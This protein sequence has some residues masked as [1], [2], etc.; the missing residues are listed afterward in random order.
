M[1]VVVAAANV[2]IFLYPG[3]IILLIIKICLCTGCHKHVVAQI[4]SFYK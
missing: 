3:I 4:E 2:Q 1:L